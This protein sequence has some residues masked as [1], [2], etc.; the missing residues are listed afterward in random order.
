MRLAVDLS[1]L[2]EPEAGMQVY[3]KNFVESLV[4]STDEPVEL[5]IYSDANIRPDITANE[6]SRLR[7]LPGL[8]QSRVIREQVVLP[9]QLWRMNEAVDRLIIPAYLGPVWVPCPVDLFVYDLEYLKSYTEYGFKDW[10]YWRVL[11]SVTYGRADRI[12]PCSQTTRKQ[13]IE[14]YPSLGQRVGPVLY[15]GKKR[16]INSSQTNNYPG[17]QKFILYVGT[18]SAR[19]NVESLVEFYRESPPE[20]FD[21]YSLKLVGHEGWGEP[22]PTKLAE[23]DEGITWEGR[24]DDQTL[25]RLYAEA[26]L[27]VL[28]SKGEGFGLP[29][30]EAFEA[31]L[32]VILS[33]IDVFREVAGEAAFYLPNLE[34]PSSWTSVFRDALFDG[35]LRREKITRGKR[36][37]KRFHWSNT[38]SRYLETIRGQASS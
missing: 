5:L 11:N 38:A 7:E 30:L 29:I 9:W 24:V 27:L 20:I 23:P 25:N 37:A 34:D 2:S 21:N 14:R 10:L 8:F 26:S 18:I 22:D 1:C 6:R 35:G 13:L 16:S 33:D 36:R 31:E 15:P 32:P 19:K 28:P 3:T 17:D 12:F 4:R